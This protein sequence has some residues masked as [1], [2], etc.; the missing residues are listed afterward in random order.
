VV[1]PG[2]LLVFEGADAAGKSA[3]SAGM[4]DEIRKQG[5][6]VELLTFPGKAPH[7]LGE[8]VYRIHHDSKALGID[9]LTPLSLQALHIAAHLDAIETRILPL[10]EQGTWVVLDRFW[11][12]TFVYGVADGVD[13]RVLQ[14]LIDAEKFLW[15]TW[16]PKMLFLVTRSSPL[17]DEPKDKWNRWNE[18]YRELVTSESV[19]Y[20][21]H[22]I[23]NENSV[24]TAISRAMSLIG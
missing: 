12:S 18:I 8:L 2:E 10:L 1:K 9:L 23:Q 3:I 21:V 24:E 4:C 17:R 15:G 19:H 20:P 6:A 16:S 14:A 5:I 13:R 11:W 7:T 22:V